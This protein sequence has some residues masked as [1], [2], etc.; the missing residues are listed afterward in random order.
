MDRVRVAIL[1]SGVI[2]RYHAR[3]CRAAPNVEL[4]AAANWRPESLARFAQEWSIACTTTD[5]QEIADD[6]G[7]D[8]VII[9]L[10]NSL[11]Q[12]ETER[13]LRAGKHVLVEKPM[14]M[15]AAQAQE[16]VRAAEEAKRFL[17]VGHMWRFDVEVNWLQRAIAAG[18]MGDIVKTKGYAIHPAGTGPMGW[19]VEKEKAGGGVVMD[20]GIHAVDTARFLL[21]EPLPVK[22]YAHIGTRYSAYDVE[23]E[24]AFVVHW[25]NGAYSL[26]ETAGWQPFAEAPEGAAQVWGTQ[27]Y[28]RTFPTQLHLSIAGAAGIFA[29]T[30]PQRIE[31]C[32]WPMYARQVEHFADCIRE[33]R[34]PKPGGAE[35]LLM[36]RVM[37][38]VYE[39]AR[40]GQAVILGG[41]GG[42]P[43]S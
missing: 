28:G 37:D 11:H 6:P 33:G 16:M 25:D 36:M 21:G 30:F 29:P 22:V 10:P 42:E 8:A 43:V 2:A 34:Q 9:C 41:P 23:D 27:G 4:L 18:V 38:A 7:V 1:G 12:A 5:F 31:Q 13:M 40:S 15:N 3:A 32:D 24:A 26:I 14:A 17:M 20:M 35:G 39:S 19:F